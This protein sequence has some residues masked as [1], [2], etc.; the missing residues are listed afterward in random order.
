MMLNTVAEHGDRDDLGQLR[1]L[2][3]IVK[4]GYGGCH[5]KNLIILR[6]KFFLFKCI[7]TVP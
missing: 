3:D 4:Y 6:V 1:R 7:G 2:D 5:L